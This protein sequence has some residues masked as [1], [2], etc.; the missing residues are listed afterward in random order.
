MEAIKPGAH[1]MRIDRSNQLFGGV[2][3]LFVNDEG[4]SLGFM[5]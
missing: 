3:P 2:R 5:D 1:V 4:L